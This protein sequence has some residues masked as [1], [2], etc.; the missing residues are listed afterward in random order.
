MQSLTDR[1]RAAHQ[2]GQYPS[3]RAAVKALYAQ[4]VAEQNRRHREFIDNLPECEHPWPWPG[5][6]TCN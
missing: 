4:A 2:A 6:T 5:C 3:Y 1:A